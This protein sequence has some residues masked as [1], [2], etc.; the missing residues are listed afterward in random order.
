MATQAPDGILRAIDVFTPNDFPSLTYIER[1]DASLERAFTAA[2]ETPNTVISVSGPSKSGKTVLAEKIIGAENLVSVSG[3]ELVKATDLWDRVLDILDQPTS[4]TV[5]RTD[6]V[7]DKGDVEAGIKGKIPLVVEAHA[8]VSG[9][10]TWTDATAIGETR[11]RGGLAQAEAL[12]RGTQ[13][14]IFIDDFH[15]MERDTQTAVARQIRAASGRG[16]KFCVAS[17]PH[18]SDD[19]V[20]SNHELRGRT[21]HIDTTFWTIDD[22]F[23]IGS[24]G[25]PQ[26]LMR[27]PDDAIRGLAIEACG[28]P[29]LMQQICLQ[30]CLHLGVRIKRD[31]WQ[32][33]G[34]AADERSAILEVAATH[35]DYSSLLREM[36]TGPRTRGTNR[37]THALIDGSKGDAYRAVL[38]G[39]ANGEPETDVPYARLLERTIAVCVTS[40]PASSGITSAVQQMANEARKM[41]ADQRILEWDDT[42]GRGTL[43]IVDPYLLFYIRNSGRLA[44]LGGV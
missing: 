28:S 23:Q 24:R 34:L 31:V 13:R 37:A 42:T 11:S 38:L 15:Y 7:A 8:K 41:Y 29:Q 43:S 10:R 17:V 36:H 32:D 40:H 35:T 18:R 5:T 25:F 33:Y 6:T 9:G 27:V 2:M 16:V 3:A 12:L 39:L 20:R 44:S 26:L 21:T 30:A 4:S 19:V 22:L 1:G 14:V